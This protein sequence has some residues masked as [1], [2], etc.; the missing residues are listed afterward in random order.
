MCPRGC[1][2]SLP[3]TE[4][5]AIYATCNDSEHRHDAYMNRGIADD[6]ACITGIANI[7]ASRTSR[8]TFPRG[9]T[10][11]PGRCGAG[12]RLR[13]PYRPLAR[14]VAPGDR[15]AVGPSRARARSP[16]QR[17]T[18]IERTCLSVAPPAGHPA[19]PGYAGVPA[20]PSPAVRRRPHTRRG[21]G[22]C[23]VTRTDQTTTRATSPA[24]TRQ[25]PE[26]SPPPQRSRHPE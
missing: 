1:R 22:P 3:V 5:I 18:A 23:D 4:T 7:R 9:D 17:L 25:Q 24:R 21:I 19:A 16:S 13:R 15:R 6:T 20:G 14:T 11:P 10:A 26:V 8:R 12:S 2:A